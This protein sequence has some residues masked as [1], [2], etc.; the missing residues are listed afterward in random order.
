MR[1]EKRAERR[2]QIEAAA[3]KLLQKNGYDGTSMLAIAKAAKA[4]NET[5]Y[6]WYGD[7]NGLFNAMVASNATLI[8]ASLSEVLGMGD[9]PLLRLK[10]SGP[11]L[12]AM[13][14]GARAIALNRAAACDKTGTLGQ[15]LS[16]GGR[17]EVFPMIC[18]LMARALE[19]EQIKARSAQ[20]A[21]GWFI[22][23][24]IGDLQVRR[25]I[26]T[27]PELTGSEISL[28]AQLAFEDF[29]KLADGKLLTKP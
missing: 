12:L 5:L 27:A 4:S 21:A 19:A 17:E 14:Q 8:K 11:V 10:N 7:K 25:V 2:A 18:A 9:D 29:M 1:E 26:G 24:L 15:T 3:Y 28:R 22:A 6:R 20:V 23:L 13:L 16:R